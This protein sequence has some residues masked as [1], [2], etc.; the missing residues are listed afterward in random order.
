[1]SFSNDKVYKICDV[2]GGLDVTR[3]VSS[4]TRNFFQGAVEDVE[5]IREYVSLAATNKG[6]VGGMADLSKLSRTLDWKGRGLNPEMTTLEAG[7]GW[8]DDRKTRS[9]DR[10]VSESS[11]KPLVGDKQSD[12]A[13]ID[14]V[15]N[16]FPWIVDRRS[17]ESKW[18]TKHQNGRSEGPDKEPF[19]FDSLY[20]AAWIGTYGDAWAYYPPFRVFGQ[21]HPLTLADLI[22]PHTGSHEYPFVEPNLPKNNPKRRTFFRNPYP[23]AAQTGLSLITVLAPVYF[24]GNFHNYTY[25]QTYI[26]STGLDIAVS[27]VSSLLDIL[28]DTLTLR[29][30][31]MVVDTSFNTI[32]ISQSVVE[33]IYPERTGFED[34][35]V[36]YS[37]ADGSIL[38]DRRNQTYLVSDTI[39]QG[40]TKLH[41]ANWTNLLSEIQKLKPGERDFSTINITLTGDPYPTEFYAMYDRWLYVADW[42]VMA[43][44][45]ALEVQNAINVKLLHNMT[46]QKNK[47]PISL[48]GEKG[49]IISGDAMIVNEGRLDL[50]ITAKSTPSWFHLNS[51]ISE[52][53]Y[54]PAGGTLPLHFDV[55]TDP[56][57]IG[58]LSFVLAFN[59]KDDDYPD[60]YFNQD[61]SLEIAVKVNP[62][63]C[64][65][66]T[67][68][69]LRV[70]DQAGN[71]ICAGNASQIGN[72]CFSNF[73]LIL[74]IMVPVLTLVIITVHVYVEEKRKQADSIWAVKISEL[75]FD[76]PP[77]VV[78]RGTFGLVIKAEYRGTMVAVKRVIPP[79]TATNATNSE[80]IDA[81]GSAKAPNLLLSLKGKINHNSFNFEPHADTEVKRSVLLRSAFD[82][83]SL[84]KHNH[85][86]LKAEFIQE[87]RLLSK[88][89]H[90]C[91]TT[92][93]GAVISKSE[94]PLLVMEYMDHGSL[95]DLL[96]NDTLVIEGDLV[97]PI[98]RDISQGMRFL[99]AANPLV[100]HGDLKSHNILVDSKF[101]AKVTDFGLSQKKHAGVF[102]NYKI[103]GRSHHDAVGTPLWM[104]PE[105]LRGES[106][107]T[108]ATDAYSF[109][110]ILYEIYSRRLPYDGED[111][112]NI[113]QL[114]ADP[115]INKRPGIPPS[116]PKEMVTMMTECLSSN[117]KS[118]PT[119]EEMDSRLRAFTVG[120]VEP[121]HIS[122]SR[123]STKTLGATSLDAN[124]LLEIFPKH[125]AE[126][127]SCGQ[128]VEPEHFDCVTIYFCDI[129]GFTTI[130]GTLSPGKVSNLLDRLYLKFDA[131][132]REHNIFKM[133]T[134]GDSWMGVTNLECSQSNDHAQRI[135]MFSI[136][137]IQVASETLIDE[138]DPR[139]GFIQIR[140]GF[141][142]G[143]VIANVVGSRNPKY[144]LFGD[145]VN[146]ASRMES[147]SAPGRILCSEQS[148]ML[149]GLQCP[150]IPLLYR[151]LTA[152]KGKGDMVTYWVNERTDIVPQCEASIIRFSEMPS[153]ELTPLTLS[154]SKVLTSTKLPSGFSFQPYS[155]VPFVSCP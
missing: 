6:I 111:T 54:L 127:L 95:F 74:G 103:S 128:K 73:L 52:K 124:L 79:L 36:T 151:G 155:S 88:L 108:A 90:P 1:M 47:F 97:L 64:V 32:V 14:T 117:P 12:M 115:I 48:N 17:V 93:M 84:K 118:R 25:N 31:A 104:A 154:S 143:P 27:S 107:N 119:F 21:G 61:I 71:C 85:E 19:L 142:S 152:V 96:H 144:S 4:N 92:I 116:M 62:R 58:T 146:V 44:A 66:L 130:A 49:Q 123:Q 153:T 26:A 101:R 106:G 46:S 40:L 136:H 134:V 70:P 67:G 10:F 80:R 91:I 69:S 110:V 30:F 132:S 141:H 131:L 94:E 133:E 8:S 16:I 129:V 38:E 33:L 18:W 60:C 51:S 77:Q 53:Y 135:A 42:V 122:Y 3:L 2:L 112:D 76:A 105:L 78:G 28:K 99:H 113:L 75:H 7:L 82:F 147:N 145:T 89:R 41:N 43:F 72:K 114:I 65:A 45:P 56:L 98:L 11:N 148:A 125:I 39:H 87:M 149:L 86:K 83:S 137:A 24:T 20:S 138:E 150:D 5:L 23:D 109:G 121:G 55:N 120:C 140:S 22:G 15:S 139:R 13:I 59:I 100:I 57:D 102:P 63:D 9:L 34:V 68:D 50:V 126:A 29:S 37:I 81:S 35:R